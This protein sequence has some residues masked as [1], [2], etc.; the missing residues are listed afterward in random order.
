M[1]YGI[2]AVSGA[3]RAVLM[4]HG[5]PPDQAEVGAQMC[6]DAELRGHRSHGVRLLRNLV[7]EY[8]HGEDRREPVRLLQETPVACRVDGGFQLSLFVHRAAVDLLADK[9]L[10]M[11][12]ALVSVRRAGVSG[13][14]G[15][16]VERLAQRGLVGIAANS[17]PVT[18]VPSG[19]ARPSLGTN[20][21]AIGLPRVS[22]P[23][24]VL[25][26]ATSA[27][28]FNELLRLREAGLPLPEGV[29]TDEHGGGTTDPALALDTDSGRGRILPFGGHRG[30]GLSLM[31]EL[32]VAAGVTGRAGG[33]K[34]ATSFG[35]PEDFSGLY[36]AYR[37][38][39]VGDADAFGR[40]TEQLVAEL[41]ADGVRLPGEVS[42]LL[43]EANIQEGT[44][45]LSDDSAGLLGLG[46]S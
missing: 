23:P 22:A 20:P 36:L 38:D 42:R 30:F 11:G 35:D 2:E 28:P 33:D 19:S 39:V 32:L 46:R 40:A 18:V 1:L 6:L 12:I 4:E 3:M 24:L 10:A 14:L 34:R 29:A 41:Q 43:R 26:M 45:E 44:V 31:V 9:A 21:I 25:D 16:F 13:A 7:R 37:P 5:V 8:E 17:S 15:H 27:I